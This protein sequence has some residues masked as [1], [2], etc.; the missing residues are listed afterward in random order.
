LKKTI[1]IIPGFGH[2]PSQKGYRA[3]S[4]VLKKEGY[5]P[6]AIKIPWKKRT[7]SENAA[8]FLKKYNKIRRKEK[9]ILGFSYGAMIALIA[10]TKADVSGLILCSL[11]P[12]FKEDIDTMQK[13]HASPMQKNRLQDF[14]KLHCGRLSQHIKAQQIHM[15]YGMKEE[16]SLIYRVQ[17]TYQQIPSRHKYLIPIQK[18]DHDIANKRYLESIHLSAKQLSS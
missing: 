13:T 17:E 5:F 2:T 11:S 1:F 18:T 12:Y 14:S 7:L 6:I 3:M 4:K 9:H 15:L 16:K 10:S 8:Y